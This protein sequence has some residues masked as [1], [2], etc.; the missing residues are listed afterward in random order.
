MT[1]RA[2]RGRSPLRVAIF[3]RASDMHAHVVRERLGRFDD[4]VCDFIAVDKIHEHPSMAWSSDGRRRGAVLPTV[5]GGR[6]VVVQEL[7]AIWWRRSP[8][9]QDTGA[10]VDDPDHRELI[11]NDCAAAVAGVTA[12]AFRGSWV[13]VPSRTRLAENKIVQLCMAR[14]C[15]LRVPRTLVT[16]D[17][18]ELR[19]F[20]RAVKAPVV[21]KALRGPLRTGVPT[22]PFPPEHLSRVEA[23]RAAPA[24]YQEY[25]S[26][27]LHLRV[28]VFGRQIL[29]ASIESE[30]LDWRGDLTVP[31]RRHR[32]PEDVGRKL[33]R[34]LAGLG[35][36]M[37]VFDMKVAGNGELVCKLCR[38]RHKSHYSAWRFMPRRDPEAL[39]HWQ[40]RI[41]DAA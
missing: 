35:L 39:R 40:S 20:L 10:P 11:D 24:I 9:T 21:V 22:S 27:S 13:S 17:P 32:L 37:G 14:A 23:I 16:Q 38:E 15:G 7:D 33:R 36:A 6:T 26:G 31:F 2:P 19:A 30:E 29:T 25:V 41:E 28:H 4:V 8:S 3:S 12:T 18:A 34:V 5:D 1:V